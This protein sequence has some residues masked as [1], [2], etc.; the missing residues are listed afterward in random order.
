MICQK[1][2]SSTSPMQKREP[3]DEPLQDE[4]GSIIVIHIHF[5]YEEE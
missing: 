4:E 5:K 2:G 3:R 1:V